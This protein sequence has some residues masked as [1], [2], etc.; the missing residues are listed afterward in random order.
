[1]MKNSILGLC[2]GALIPIAFA[3]PDTHCTIKDS[4]VCCKSADGTE[5]CQLPP[6]PYSFTHHHHH[7]DDCTQHCWQVGFGGVCCVMG[8][9]SIWCN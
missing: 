3:Q 5:K 9:C 6:Y 8:D 1:M 7:Y 2:L 4:L